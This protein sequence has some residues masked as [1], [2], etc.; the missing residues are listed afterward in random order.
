MSHLAVVYLQGLSGPPVESSITVEDAVVRI[1]SV[2]FCFA[3]VLKG[4]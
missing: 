4:F 2:G 3:L 1:A